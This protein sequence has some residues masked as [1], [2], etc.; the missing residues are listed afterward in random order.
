MHWLAWT[1]STCRAGSEGAEAG[2]WQQRHWLGTWGV[3]GTA[4][5]HRWQLSVQVPGMGARLAPV[6]SCPV[7]AGHTRARCSAGGIFPSATSSQDQ[8]LSQN[9]SPGETPAAWGIRAVSQWSEQEPRPLDSWLCPQ[10]WG[11]NEEQK[12]GA[13]PG[14]A[15][16][17]LGGLSHLLSVPQAP[18]REG[19][20]FAQVKLRWLMS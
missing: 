16:D 19:Q 14:F 5:T 7:T 13:I 10:P 3:A 11:I 6:R 17:S 12:P 8:A 2:L 1:R 9:C 15:A 18:F 20:D 4:A